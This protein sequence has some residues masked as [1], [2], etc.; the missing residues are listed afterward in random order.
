MAR[1]TLVLHRVW[2]ARVTTRTDWAVMA[3]TQQQAVVE[4]T[5]T[6]SINKQFVS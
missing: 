2:L 5:T 3:R 1:P 6:G 4:C